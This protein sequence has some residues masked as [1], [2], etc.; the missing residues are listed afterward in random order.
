M[1]T[2]MK[3]LFAY[4]PDFKRIEG[5]IWA[6]E[7]GEVVE[8][9]LMPNGS[10]KQ[11]TLNFAS[12]LDARNQLGRSMYPLYPAEIG[13]LRSAF[14]YLGKAS[15]LVELLPEAELDEQADIATT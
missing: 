7:T 4:T 5:V 1:N 2:P 3:V 13:D 14:K 15:D 6:E 12:L 9:I 8:R 11:R 10:T